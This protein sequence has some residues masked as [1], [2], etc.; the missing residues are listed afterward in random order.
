MLPSVR[1]VASTATAPGSGLTSALASSVLPKASSAP[2]FRRG[3]QRRASSSKP[4]RSDNG[5]S[6]IPDQSVPAS[7]SARGQGKAGGEKRKRKASGRNAAAKK[8]PSV[9]STHH[10]VG[11]GT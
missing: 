5:S 7:A 11:E 2:F 8:L 1:R 9:P 3:H 4:S 6:D 10:M